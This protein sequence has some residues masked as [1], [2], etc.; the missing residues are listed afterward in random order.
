MNITIVISIVLFPP[1]AFAEKGI[2]D[3]LVVFFLW[4]YGFVPGTIAGLT[5]LNNQE[6][7]FNNVARV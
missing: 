2:G 6:F 7:N 5:I 4:L 1:V 3:F